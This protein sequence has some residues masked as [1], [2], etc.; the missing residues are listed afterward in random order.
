MGASEVAGPLLSYGPGRDH[1]GPTEGG[2]VP[3]KVGG[4]RPSA[5][6]SGQFGPLN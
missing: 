3:I 4:D 1:P 2:V 5:R 6:S